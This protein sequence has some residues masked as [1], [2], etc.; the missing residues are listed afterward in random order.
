MTNINESS[1][2]VI[3][4]GDSGVGKTSL[5]H[6]AK[7]GKF[8]SHSIPTI[9]AGITQMSTTMSGILCNYQLWD[10]AGQE[11]Y[12][13]IV[14]IYFKGAVSAILV[15]SMIDKQSFLNLQGWIDQLRDHAETGINITIV[16]NKIDNERLAIEEDEARKWAMD[17]SFSIFFTSAVT[18]Q[19]IDV[20]LDHITATS[21]LPMKVQIQQPR[22]VYLKQNKNNKCC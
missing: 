12:R 7:Y 10:T 1:P 17:R 15:F 2:R 16:G 19:N 3:L 18:G 13:N 9:G 14:P 5:I 21:I 8:D 22:T 6:R 20:L 11:I 4:I